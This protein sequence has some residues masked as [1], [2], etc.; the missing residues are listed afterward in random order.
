V[1]LSLWSGK[2]REREREK[3][4]EKRNVGTKRPPLG[5]G[6]KIACAY[7]LIIS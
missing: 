6:N 1:G 3:R 2:E 5:G 7:G 4:L